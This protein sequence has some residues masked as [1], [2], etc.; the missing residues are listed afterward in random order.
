MKVVAFIG[1]HDSF[2][3]ITAEG[4][5]NGVSLSHDPYEEAI[6]RA[7]SIVTVAQA[8]GRPLGPGETRKDLAT[9]CMSTPSVFTNA[10]QVFKDCMSKTACCTASKAPAG[11]V[12]EGEVPEEAVAAV[13]EA[14]AAAAPPGKVPGKPKA[15]AK[16]PKAAPKGKP[17]AAPK[18]KAS[19]LRF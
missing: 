17:K 19:R 9:L 11:A 10:P 18:P 15:A 4:E 1:G 7:L 2:R 16:T 8:F 12:G 5:R 13:A 6:G 3:A 14:P